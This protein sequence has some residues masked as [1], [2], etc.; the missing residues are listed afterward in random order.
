MRISDCSL[1]VCS[2]D[3]DG[4]LRSI[5]IRLPGSADAESKHED[6]RKHREPHPHRRR[7]RRPRRTIGESDD[8]D[9]PPH[10]HPRPR[11]AGT[12]RAPDHAA[13]PEGLALAERVHTTDHRRQGLRRTRVRV[14]RSE[15]HTS[16][17]Q[18]LMRLSYAVFCLKKQKKH[19][20]HSHILTTN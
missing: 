4:P 13:P 16:E 8:R 17:L 18:S 12:L 20:I 19:T 1:D 15:E 5:L 10:P 6:S 2:S 14:V 7:D 3:V 9:D 11:T